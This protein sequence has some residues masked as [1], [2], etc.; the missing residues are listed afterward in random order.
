VGQHTCLRGAAMPHFVL[1]IKFNKN[2]FIV[3]AQ[4]IA[5]KFIKVGDDWIKNG[6]NKI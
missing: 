6:P 4:F 2:I 1:K 3:V 5:G